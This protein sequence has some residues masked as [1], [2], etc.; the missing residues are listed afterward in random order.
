M[1]MVR[2]MQNILCLDDVNFRNVLLGIILLSINSSMIGTIAFVKKKILACDA[3]SHATLSGV[4][5]VFAFLGIKHEIWLTV[6]ACFTS[7]LAFMAIEYIVNHSKIKM[8]NVIAMVS[9]ISFG[10]GSFLLS[11]LQHRNLPEQGGL[12]YFLFGNAASLLQKDIYALCFLSVFSIALFSIYAS[13]FIA[14]AFDPLYARSI[15]MPVK[16][17]DFIFMSLM[18]VAIVVGIRTV[19]LL[20]MSAM[21]ISPVA[22]G[23]FFSHNICHIVM[24]AIGISLVSALCGVHIS[25]RFPHLPTGP[26]IIIIMSSIAY[27]S[28]FLSWLVR[29]HSRKK[30]PV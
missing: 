1:A 6:G 28:F 4:C 18:I 22:V 5:L 25:Y 21:F 17:I 2:L 15:G 7:Y 26:W 20:L 29:I 11:I 23:R 8:G 16:K 12:Q 3:V 9:S 27:I 30:L 10:I 24:L 19:G 13:P 14:V